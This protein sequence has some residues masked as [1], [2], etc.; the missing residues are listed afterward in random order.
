MTANTTFKQQLGIGAGWVLMTVMTGITCV[1]CFG[2]SWAATGA[3]KASEGIEYL[4]EK[5]QEWSANKTAENARRA[6]SNFKEA[7]NLYRQPAEPSTTEQETNVP[8]ENVSNEEVELQS[9]DSKVN[10]DEGY[11]SEDETLKS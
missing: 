8:N 5:G 4:A 11:Q 9:T 6:G 3:K 10:N 2:L 7:Y 1:F